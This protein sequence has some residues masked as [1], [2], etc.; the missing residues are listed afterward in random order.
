MIV[1]RKEVFTP[2]WI[3]TAE[4]YEDIQPETEVLETRFVSYAGSAI[5]DALD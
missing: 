1:C 4:D 3:Q 5:S 2:L